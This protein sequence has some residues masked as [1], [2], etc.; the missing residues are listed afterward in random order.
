MGYVIQPGNKGQLVDDS[1]IIYSSTNCLDI[2]RGVNKGDENLS[3][4]STITG[5]TKQFE[6]PEIIKKHQA[7]KTKLDELNKKLQNITFPTTSVVSLKDWFD[8]MDAYV[9]SL[10]DMSEETTDVYEVALDPS[11][12]KWKYTGVVEP[13]DS[14]WNEELNEAKRK[15][16]EELNAKLQKISDSMT[17]L[18]Q[19]LANRMGVC[20]P[21]IKIINLIKKVPS[22]QDIIDWARS[23]IS[24]LVYLYDL[25]FNVY[26]MAMEILELVVIR[27]PQLVSKFMMKMAKFNCSINVKTTSIK[28]NKN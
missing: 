21:F 28:I 25:I 8:K 19:S 17:E 20:G 26:K 15:L 12:N 13:M 1:Y 14:K 16:C 23:V 7:D 2:I 11:D 3:G 4:A 27:F 6:V 5:S 9:D 24:F 22:L 18:L 10:P